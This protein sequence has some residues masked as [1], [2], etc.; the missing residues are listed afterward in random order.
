MLQLAK[1]CEFSMILVQIVTHKKSMLSVMHYTVYTGYID[2]KSVSHD[3]ILRSI[4]P[5]HIANIVY[6]CPQKINIAYWS[7]T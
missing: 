7:H 6:L 4:K 2:V 5:D 3:T 1:T